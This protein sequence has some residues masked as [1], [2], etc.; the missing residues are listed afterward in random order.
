MSKIVQLPLNQTKNVVSL[1]TYRKRQ[2]VFDL[3]THRRKLLAMQDEIQRIK[4][5]LLKAV[6]DHGDDPA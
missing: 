3:A 6:K 4:R 2:L 1:E 5:A